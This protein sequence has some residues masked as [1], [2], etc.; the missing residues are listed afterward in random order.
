MYTRKMAIPVLP[1]A[2]RADDVIIMAYINTQ[3]SASKYTIMAC[4]QR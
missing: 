3:H 2:R 4:W 1:E